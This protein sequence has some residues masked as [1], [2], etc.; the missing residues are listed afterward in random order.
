MEITVN[1]STRQINLFKIWNQE[2]DALGIANYSFEG[3]QIDSVLSY[4]DYFNHYSSNV[5]KE[6]VCTTVTQISYTFD[7]N[8]SWPD[9]TAINS[10]CDQFSSLSVSFTAEE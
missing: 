6:D 8:N 2:I 4:S 5:L 7:F 3:N 9:L 1:R 10:S